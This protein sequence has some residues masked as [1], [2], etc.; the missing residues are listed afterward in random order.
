MIKE[1][2]K[3]GLKQEKEKSDLKKEIIKKKSKD[4]QTSHN[5]EY[6]KSHFSVE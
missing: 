6:N 5:K 2:K 1:K 3:Y 4:T